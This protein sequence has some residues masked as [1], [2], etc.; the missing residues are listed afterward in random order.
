MK[1]KVKVGIKD[2]IERLGNESDNKE[3]EKEKQESLNNNKDKTID[4]F[5]FNNRGYSLFKN[6]FTSS[7]K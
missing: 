6:G 7:K 4:N 2:Y 3:K 1:K 5:S